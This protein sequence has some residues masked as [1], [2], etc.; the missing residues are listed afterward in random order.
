MNGLCLSAQH[1][2]AA[3]EQQRF[4][5]IYEQDLELYFT[6]DVC[7]WRVKQ[8]CIGVTTNLMDLKIYAVNFLGPPFV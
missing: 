5:A 8:L 4:L 3:Q 7:R 2:T 1:E 6:Q